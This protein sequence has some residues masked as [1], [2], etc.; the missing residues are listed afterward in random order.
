VCN[1]DGEERDGPGRDKVKRS[2]FAPTEIVTF[3]KKAQLFQ[4]TLVPFFFLLGGREYYVIHSSYYSF[5]PLQ[6]ENGHP[7]FPP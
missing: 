5:L 6:S 1:R 7:L 4:F 3:Q 2:R